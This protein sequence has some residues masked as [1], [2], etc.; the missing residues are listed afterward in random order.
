[1]ISPIRFP[2]FWIDN[3][4]KLVAEFQREHQVIEVVRA[5]TEYCIRILATVAALPYLPQA[6]AHF[7]LA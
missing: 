6:Y 1:M 5:S 3:D 2:S 4:E 7:V